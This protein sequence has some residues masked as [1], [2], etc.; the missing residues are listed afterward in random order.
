[1]NRKFFSLTIIMT[2]ILSIAGVANAQD[3]T[4]R[5]ALW[6]TNQLPAYEECA[7]VFEE[8]NPGID[9]VIEQLGWGDYWTAITTGFVTGDTP[10]VFTNH[11]AKYPEFL[12]LEQIVDIQPLVERDGVATDIY[13]DGLADLW[14]R[15]GGRYGLPK[16]W[17]TIAVVYNAE[18]LEAAGVEAS[19]LNELTW[20]FDDGGSFEEMVARLSIDAN[21]NNG[22]S[23]DFDP[24]NVVQYGFL[25]SDSGGFSGQT[26]WSAFA[27][28]TGWHFTGGEVWAE[29]YFYADERFINTVD[30]YFSL[31]E[32][33]FA[34]PLS[35][36]QGLGQLAMFQAGQGALGL[37]GS[38][39]IGSYLGSEF[40][41]GFARLPEGPEGRASMFN[42]LADSIWTGTD[43]LE[44]SWEWVKFLAS[45]DCQQIVGEAGVVFPA[46]PSAAE[47][48]LQV[49]ADAGFDVSAFTDQAFEE[50][51]TFLFPITDFGGEIATIM[52][53]TTDAIALGEVDA[54]TALTEANEEVNSLFE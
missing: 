25:Y 43:N 47:T 54:A 15:D 37:D 34:P 10:D 45:A 44:E 46:I 19:E 16:D 4:I 12:V 53:E 26:Q 30:W 32:K 48:S 3:V 5:Y 21:G 13:L 14:T 1:M 17:D 11:L 20:N 35:D 22:L 49:R 8:A 52:Q 6:D 51:G 23:E 39:M 29:E 18:M 41:V 42:G 28:S 36:V 27:G 50:G 33:G 31:V 38:W 2:F 9:I 24:S 40:E 7:A